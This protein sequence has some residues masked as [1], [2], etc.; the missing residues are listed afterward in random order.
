ME[1]TFCDLVLEVPWHSFILG[2]S[3]FRFKSEHSPT[4]KPAHGTG[5]LHVSL[6]IS[7]LV[8]RVVT[9]EGNSR[10]LWERQRQIYFG[11]KILKSIQNFYKFHFL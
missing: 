1:M 3:L 6:T 7:S 2:T 9:D 8:P 10:T 5:M 11:V 4:T